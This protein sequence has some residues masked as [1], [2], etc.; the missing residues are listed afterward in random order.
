MLLTKQ[1][2]NHKRKKGLR[3][4]LQHSIIMASSVRFFTEPWRP[5]LL[6]EVVFL[7]IYSEFDQTSIPVL[8]SNLSLHGRHACS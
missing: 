7:I 8:H 2:V 4:R 3:V 5:L 6:T 1:M